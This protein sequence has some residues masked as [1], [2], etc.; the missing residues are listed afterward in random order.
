ME[1]TIRAAG[2][3]AGACGVFGAGGG[4][5]RWAPQVDRLIRSGRFDPAKPQV[6]LLDSGASLVILVGC[7]EAE[8]VRHLKGLMGQ[9]V[10]MA[11]EEKADTLEIDLDT[12]RGGMEPAALVRMAAQAVLGSA[13][14]VLESGKHPEQLKDEVCSPAGTTIQ[15]VSALEEGGFRSALIKA[16]DACY[17]KSTE[18]Q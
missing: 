15:G 5:T 8:D 7:P 16:C 6:K 9:A 3:D 18:I 4:D 1:L 17:R 12:Y 14:M 13:R 10:R 2:G 11:R